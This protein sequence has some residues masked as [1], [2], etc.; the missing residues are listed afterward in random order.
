MTTIHQG[1]CVPKSTLGTRLGRGLVVEGRKS[2]G[3]RSRVRKSRSRKSWWRVKGR[4]VCR[5]LIVLNCTKHSYS[6]A[7]HCLTGCYK[8]QSLD[9]S[10]VFSHQ[11]PTKILRHYGSFTILSLETACSCNCKLYYLSEFLFPNNE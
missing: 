3:H 8:T 6:E 4:R 5:F 11:L 1:T 9:H 10:F 2:R 7:K